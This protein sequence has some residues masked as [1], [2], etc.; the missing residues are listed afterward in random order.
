MPAGPIGSTEGMRVTHDREAQVVLG[1]PGAVTPTGI[2]EMGMDFGADPMEDSNPWVNREKPSIHPEGSTSLLAKPANRSVVN[3]E[4]LGTQMFDSVM[5]EGQRQP[6]TIPANS[7]GNDRDFH[8]IT[9]T[10]TSPDLRLT[11]YRRTADPDRAIR[12]RDSPTSAEMSRTRS[13]SY[14]LQITR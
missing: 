4:K 6:M 12:S 9:E 14:R 1:S 10:W 11:V 13:C 5:A 3:I 8:V 2:F 7:Q